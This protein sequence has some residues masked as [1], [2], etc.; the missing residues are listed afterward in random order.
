MDEFM[1]I[2][3]PQ[4]FAMVVTIFLLIRFENALKSLEDKIQVSLQSL[5]EKVETKIDRIEQA[6]SRNNRLLA[7][8]IF[9]GNN[10]LQDEGENRDVEE[11]LCAPHPVEK[12][13]CKTS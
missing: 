9:K 12:Q 2:L 4:N 3:T 5:E 10:K 11:I 13:V 6:I 7:L 8:L 1:K